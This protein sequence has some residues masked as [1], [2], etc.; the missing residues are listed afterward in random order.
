VHL[1]LVVFEMIGWR[2]HL[3]L[4]WSLMMQREEY[5]DE[6]H[7]HRYEVNPDLVDQLEQ[8]GL[9][10]VGKDETVRIC[11]SCVHYGNWHCG[12]V[13]QH[14]I[15]SGHWPLLRPSTGFL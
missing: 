3:T 8:H 9:R 14:G 7:R 2:C 13:M 4:Q 15:G 1:G 12:H 10:F 5:I 6:R 11:I